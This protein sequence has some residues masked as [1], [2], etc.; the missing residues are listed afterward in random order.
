MDICSYPFPHWVI[1]ITHFSQSAVASHFSQ[2]SF[3]V[4]MGLGMSDRIIQ[5]L[6]LLCVSS[7]LEEKSLA[8][9]G[10]QFKAQRKYFFFTGCY[11]CSVRRRLES[12]P[13]VQCGSHPQGVIRRN[14]L[15]VRIWEALLISFIILTFGITTASSC[16]SW[17][18]QPPERLPEEICTRGVQ[19][20]RYSA[21]V[22]GADVE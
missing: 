19:K 21:L 1:R 5:S 4:L 2:S 15:T 14:K 9:E 7:H 10:E 22:V 16:Y 11:F 20:P 6:N 13:G 18:P 3:H 12:A 17:E 8:P